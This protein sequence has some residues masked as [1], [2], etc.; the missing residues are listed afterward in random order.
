LWAR[1]NRVK[2]RSPGK[3]GKTVTNDYFKNLQFWK[4]ITGSEKG[5]VIYAGDM[6]QKR[7]NGTN[8]IPW[9]ALEELPD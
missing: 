3:A 8:V 5:S 1:D 7:S 4:R 6:L 2:Q 9:N